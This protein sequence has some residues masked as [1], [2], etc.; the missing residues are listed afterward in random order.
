MLSGSAVKGVV[1]REELPD[2]AEEFFFP[3]TAAQSRQLVQYQVDRKVDFIKTYNFIPRQAYFALAEAAGRA[4][5][6]FAGHVPG[7]V[8]VMEAAEAGQ[9]SIEHARAIPYDCSSYGSEYREAIRRYSELEPSSA[10]PGH[11]DRLRK[12]MQGFDL[13]RC[14]K[15]LA[16]LRENDV[17][18][19]PTHLTREADAR[20]PDADYRN[21]SRRKY[22][23][24]PLHDWWVSDWDKTASNSSTVKDL[25]RQFFDHGL[26]ITG[27]AH[28]AGVK[29]MVGTDTPDAGVYAGFSYHDELVHLAN[30]GL[31]PMDILRAASTV[32]ADYFGLSETYG[33]VAGGMIADLILLNDNPLDDIRNTQSIVAV[34]F[35]GR[36]F[37][38]AA[39]DDMLMSVETYVKTFDQ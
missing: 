2:G 11:E 4:G 10:V 7:A 37:D 39:L 30:A 28:Q 17:Y 14:K 38:R 23:P 5:L 22:I 20:A 18:Y 6:E 29:V 15:V 26:M 34:I 21:D 36:T 19:V 31:E 12:T 25:F 16:T 13:S 27:L 24:K 32:P 3:A 33:G 1:L 35:S 9:R 8:S